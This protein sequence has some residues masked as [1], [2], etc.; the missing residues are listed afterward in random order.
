MCYAHLQLQLAVAVHVSEVL[1]AA[2]APCCQP[3]AVLAAEIQ[4][5][6][7]QQPS[8]HSELEQPPAPAPAPAGLLPVEHSSN[9]INRQVALNARL[10]R[11]MLQNTCRSQGLCTT[12]SSAKH[13]A[14][15]RA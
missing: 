7:G 4:C 15:A 8:S 12:A 9:G 1:L 11:C 6:Q 5:E 3:D 10:H 2:V 13:R 14:F